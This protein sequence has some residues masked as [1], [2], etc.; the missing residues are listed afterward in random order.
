MHAT[1]II[2]HGLAD[3][4]T[5]VARDASVTLR[6]A[7]G[8][9]AYAGALWWRELIAELRA[10]TGWQALAWLDCGDQT[11][12]AVEAIRCGVVHL[13]LDTQSPTLDDIREIAHGKE[14]EV[15]SLLF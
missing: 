7:P 13:I 12:L 6:S 8:A 15:K 2:I 1:S 11:A 9:A 10:H 4:K 14:G 3:A 5:A